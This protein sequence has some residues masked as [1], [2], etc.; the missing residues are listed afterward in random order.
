MA[1]SLYM[2]WLQ[3]FENLGSNGSVHA[4]HQGILT[5]PS[6][7]NVE[8]RYGQFSTYYSHIKMLDG[9]ETGDEVS[10]GDIIGHIELRPDEALCLC[11]WSSRKYSCSTGPH[12]HWEVRMN[13]K[14]RIP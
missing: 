11:D 1:P 6:T 9:L 5:T 13:G 10:Q 2:D 4:S 12:L 14:P 3:N 7:C 8:I